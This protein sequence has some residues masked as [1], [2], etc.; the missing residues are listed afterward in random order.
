MMISPEDYITSLIIDPKTNSA[1]QINTKILNEINNTISSDNF[2]T[3]DDL[4]KY[5]DEVDNG[6]IGDVY[7]L[8]KFTKQLNKY[9]NDYVIDNIIATN[10]SIVE[11]DILNRSY[12]DYVLKNKVE[13][14]IEEKPTE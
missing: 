10:Q 13:K 1:F 5:I 2:K 3:I 7:L 12:L 9:K 6:C 14:S 4:R 8:K 11:I